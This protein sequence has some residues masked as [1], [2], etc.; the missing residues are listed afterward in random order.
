MPKRKFVYAV[1]N[2]RVIM[3]KKFKVDLSNI[4]RALN[5]KTNSVLSRKIRSYAINV[6]DCPYFER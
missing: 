1:S 2:D 4:S 3:M 5:F 6:L